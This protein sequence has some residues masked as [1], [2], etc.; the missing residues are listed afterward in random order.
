MGGHIKEIELISKLL[1]DSLTPGVDFFSKSKNVADDIAELA[2]FEGH[3]TVI[4]ENTVVQD[5]GNNIIKAHNTVLATGVSR[6]NDFNNAIGNFINTIIAGTIYGQ[7]MSPTGNITG[8]PSGSREKFTEFGPGVKGDRP[9]E[10]T[11]DR[12]SYRG[13][14][15]YVKNL[16]SGYDVAMHPEWAW[17]HYHLKP[18]GTYT[19]D[20]DGKE[21]RFG[22]KTGARNPQ[23]ED[24]FKGADVNVTNHFHI[25]GD[26]D[27]V[28]KAIKDNHHILARHVAD[29]MR[30]ETS[31]RANV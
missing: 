8:A 21:H 9:G 3:N 31:L 23:N 12:N 13:I 16:K 2:K 10:K 7:G 29:A 6:L 5:I 18:G 25:T 14:D 20:K 22:D 4:K 17:S 15:A 27:S 24:F 1:M 26:S 19:S 30:E 11:Y 28:L